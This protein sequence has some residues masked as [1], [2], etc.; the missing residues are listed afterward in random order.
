MACIFNRVLPIDR[1]CSKLSRLSPQ[2][3]TDWITAVGEDFM[4]SS[5]SFSLSWKVTPAAEFRLAADNRSTFSVTISFFLASL[6]FLLVLPSQAHT[7]TNDI[8]WSPATAL[9][10][11]GDIGMRIGDNSPG[12]VMV[13]GTNFDWFFTDWGQELNVLHGPANQPNQTSL[14]FAPQTAGYAS[15]INLNGIL[16]VPWILG[17]YKDDSTG[18]IYALIHLELRPS[19]GNTNWRSRLA[20]AISR[21]AGLDWTVQGYIIIQHHECMCGESTNVG[22][23]GIVVKDGY[24]YIWYDDGGHPATAR[25]AL[26][27]VFVGAT[28]R[29]FKYYKGSFSQPGLG[30]KSTRLNEW[31]GHHTDV[32]FNTYLKQFVVA[33]GGDSLILYFSNDGITW[34]NPVQVDAGNGRRYWYTVITS[35][36]Y[37]EG[38]SGQTFDV[39]YWDVTQ[40]TQSTSDT[41]FMQQVTIGGGSFL[42]SPPTHVS[43]VAN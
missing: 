25:A 33:I 11:S 14:R 37:K 27:D 16:P 22:G 1:R 7:Q 35:S 2:L 6:F 9:F 23:S 15:W 3:G 13:D 29:W 26:S 39:G 12:V 38:T 32:S 17:T 31:V 36:G 18:N 4:R 21:D 8:A 24:M 40:P 19:D 10:T 43:V 41:W 34:G 20:I 42:P 30:G 5:R 28:H